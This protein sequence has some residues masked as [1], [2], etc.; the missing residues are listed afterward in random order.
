M[1][2]SAMEGCDKPV[3]HRLALSLKVVGVNEGEEEGNSLF[4]SR[5]IGVNLCITKVP[6]LCGD[7]GR[8]CSEEEEGEC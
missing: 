7:A 2:S 6:G 1:G 8:G 4:P 5:V 3:G